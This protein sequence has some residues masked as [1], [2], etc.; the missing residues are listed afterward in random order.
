LDRVPTLPER[1]DS[2]GRRAQAAQDR[3]GWASWNDHEE[4]A[5]GVLDLARI[6]NDMTTLL[7]WMVKELEGKSDE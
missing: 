2:L 1:I 3:I 4:M 7:Y 5:G 6:V